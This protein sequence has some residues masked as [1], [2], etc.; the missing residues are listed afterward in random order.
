MPPKKAHKFPVYAVVEG[1][2]TGIFTDWTEAKISTNK[3]SGNDYEGFETKEQAG[4][5]MRRHNVE[6]T[7]VHL[8]HRQVLLS[9]YEADTVEME[10]HS[11]Q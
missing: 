9:N 11:I 10:T 5:Y 2:T 6:D 8:K 7:I 4:A 1:R 3:F